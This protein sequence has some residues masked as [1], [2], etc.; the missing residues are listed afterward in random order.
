MLGV[1]LIPVTPSKFLYEWLMFIVLY[2]QETAAN[3]HWQEA[4]EHFP[5]VLQSEVWA[6]QEAAAVVL[7]V[8]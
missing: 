4:R 5:G 1:F 3:C 8:A 7:L 2:S 6:D